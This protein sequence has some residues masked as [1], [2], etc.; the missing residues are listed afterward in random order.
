MLMSVPIM[1]TLDSTPSTSSKFDI[2]FFFWG[3]F[4][5]GFNISCSVWDDRFIR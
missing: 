1:P 5:L 4:S 2:F 3:A